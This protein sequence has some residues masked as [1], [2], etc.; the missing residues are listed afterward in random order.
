MRRASQ[1]ANDILMLDIQLINK[2]LSINF[3]K[4]MPLLK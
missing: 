3:A 1:S 2:E 4:V